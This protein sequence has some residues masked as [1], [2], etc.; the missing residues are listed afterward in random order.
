VLAAGLI[1][2]DPASTPGSR[3]RGRAATLVNA[4]L[5]AGPDDL[6]YPRFAGDQQSQAQLRSGSRIF[7]APRGGRVAR[8]AHHH[9]DTP[10]ARSTV[11]L[12]SVRGSSARIADDVSPPARRR[13]TAARRSG[14][15]GATDARVAGSNGG[16][17]TENERQCLVDSQQLAR[18]EPTRRWTEALRIDHRGLLD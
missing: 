14:S 12:T 17:E 9:P 8:H 16:S 6:Q 15:Q 10:P 3:S 7:E 4:D 5:A 18:F 1:R 2:D 11:A 13:H